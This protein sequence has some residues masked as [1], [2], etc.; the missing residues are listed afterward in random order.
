MLLPKEM[1]LA[2]Q[3][4]PRTWRKI[5]IIRMF[6]GSR[7]A[8]EMGI[9]YPEHTLRNKRLGRIVGEIGAILSAEAKNRRKSGARTD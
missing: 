6:N 2:P 3:F 4:F 7:Q 9:C 5:E 8:R 1:I